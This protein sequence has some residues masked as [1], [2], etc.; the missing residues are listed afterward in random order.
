[1]AIAQVET[2]L[3]SEVE[4]QKNKS[5]PSAAANPGKV[6]D[7]DVDIDD[8]MLESAFPTEQFDF[9]FLQPLHPSPSLPAGNPLAQELISLGLDEPLP[10]QHIIDELYVELCCVKSSLV[11]PTPSVENTGLV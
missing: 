7:I 6:W 10:P 11:F 9:S 1:L 3:V 2:K 5:T 8:A 4:A